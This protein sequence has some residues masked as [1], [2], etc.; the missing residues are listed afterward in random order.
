M[1]KNIKIYSLFGEKS[2]DKTINF[3]DKL[4]ILVGIN[5]SGKTTCL[6]ILNCIMTNTYSK[7]IE[8]EF[9]LIVLRTTEGSIKI[10]KEKDFDDEQV[11]FVN[12]KI[13]NEEIEFTFRSNSYESPY[14]SS[15]NIRSSYNNRI[16][17]YFN[18]MY[19]P[20]F[21]RIETDFLKLSE[22]VYDD[23]SVS[24]STYENKYMGKRYIESLS[25][26][27]SNQRS[28]VLGLTNDDI[29]SIVARKWKEVTDYETQELNILIKNFFLSIIEPPSDKDSVIGGPG[30]PG[31]D[32]IGGAKQLYTDL[33][34]M[35]ITAG[36][37]EE[38]DKYYDRQIKR[39]TMEVAEAYNNTRDYSENKSTE[40]MIDSLTTLISHKKIEDLLVMYRET[41][42]KISKRKAH[43]EDLTA[44]L[45]NFLNKETKLKNGKLFF[46]KNEYPLQYE[47]LSAGEKQLVALFVYTKLAVNENSVLLLDE[48]E[49]SLHINWQRKFLKSLISA[50]ENKQFIISTHSPFII[51]NFQDHLVE[52]GDMEG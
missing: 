46:Y 5:G 13:H 48:P 23:S 27:L 34:N 15:Y 29:N 28:M 41:H 6:D 37:I 3:D 2:N 33:K 49:L 19:F 17:W 44:T 4:T 24:L 42:E 26:D 22:S 21:R 45:S 11:L 51:S 16:Q 40:T 31:Y 12:G 47:D 10:R 20:T 50:S 25:H 36:Y 38:E 43:F 39:Y 1:L 7:L 52:L 8:H 35:F 18:S 32:D 14:V 9:D 30:A